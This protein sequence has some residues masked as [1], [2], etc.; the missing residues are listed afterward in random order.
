MGHI[1]MIGMMGTGKTTVGALVAEQLT[2]SFM[3]LDTEIMVHTGRTIPELFEA[4]EERFR[5]MESMVLARLAEG[6]PSVISTGGGSIL[7]P[8]NVEIMR[9]TGTL[10][11]LTAST[12][13]IT[14]RIRDADDRPL[15]TDTSA[16]SDLAISRTASYE[17]AAD[18]T[19]DTDGKSPDVVAEEVVMCNVT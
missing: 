14:A 5:E 7:R 10:V 18:V 12:A 4:G 9:R 15:A 19:V 13:E 2:R 8:S 1:W 11:L 6:D 16:L 17:D 3:D